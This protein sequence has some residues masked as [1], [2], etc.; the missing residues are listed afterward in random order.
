MSFFIFKSILYTNWSNIN[1]D[2][3]LVFWSI[4]KKSVC[5]SARNK[6]NLGTI[7]TFGNW[8]RFKKIRSFFNHFSHFCTFLVLF[9][10]FRVKLQASDHTQ[11]VQLLRP[12]LFIQ[13]PTLAPSFSSYG[14]SAA[15][16]VWS[17]WALLSCEAPICSPF[18]FCS[19][20]PSIWILF[21]TLRRNG[22][23]DQEIRVTECWLNEKKGKVAKIGKLGKSDDF[24]TSCRTPT[25]HDWIV[26]NCLLDTS[27]C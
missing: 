9:V 23:S 10:V 15:C 24:E 22:A 3:E 25:L 14:T 5:F 4:N 26:Y 17:S 8:T 16:S 13:K 20:V 2:L 6:N 19:I 21:L 1:L 11:V 7:N 27:Q 12:L 18:L